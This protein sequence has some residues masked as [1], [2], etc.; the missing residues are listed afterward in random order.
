MTIP[1]SNTIT[2]GETYRSK[3]GC[4][5]VTYHPEWDAKQPWASYLLG[6]AGRH[7]ATLEHACA[8]FKLLGHPLVIPPNTSGE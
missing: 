2:S 4:A 3:D 5:R 7:F 1:N 6:T 8:H